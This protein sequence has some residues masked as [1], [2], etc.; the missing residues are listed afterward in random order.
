MQTMLRS[1]LRWIV[2]YFVVAGLAAALVYARFPRINI[3]LGAGA[4]AG[5]FLWFGLA[6]LLAIGASGAEARLIRKGME[7]G[8]P[9]DGEKVAVLGTV[10]SSFETFESP[11]TRRRALIYEYKVLPAGREQAG[12]FDGF[13]MAPTTIEGPRGSIRLLAAP[14]L[15][16]PDEIERGPEQ[17]RNLKEYVERTDWTVHEGIDI[18]REIAHLKTVLADDDGRIRYDIRREKMDTDFSRMTLQ[19]KVVAPGDRV[20]AIGWF[21]SAR[22]GLVPHTTS[23]LHSVKI[24]KGDAEEILK[25]SGRSGLTSLLMGCGCLLPVILAATIALALIPLDAIEQMIEAKDPSWTEVRVERW[26]DRNVRRRFA[27]LT[28]TGEIVIQLEPGQ[29]RGK[30]NDIPLRHTYLKRDGDSIEIWLMS[31]GSPASGAV[32]RFHRGGAVESAH[33]L[34]GATIPASEIE[35]EQLHDRDDGVVGRITYL[36]NDTNLRAAFHA[37]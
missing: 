29:A 21:S 35:V 30:L 7:G 18:K 2:L 33:V 31:D 23:I 34:G 15:A 1:C 5:F 6:Y 8:R 37:R 19:E 28:P 16:F 20:C 3:A 32:I 11:I 14:E 12:I 25:K 27:A 24:I 10:S 17:I 13:A 9:N 4:A 26:I 36:S 22:G